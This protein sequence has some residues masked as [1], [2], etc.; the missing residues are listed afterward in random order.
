MIQFRLH[1]I[2][3]LKFESERWLEASVVASKLGAKR[4]F[5]KALL[6]T[7]EQRLKYFCKSPV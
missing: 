4:M 1:V 6:F 7:C 3:S 5:T 2:S